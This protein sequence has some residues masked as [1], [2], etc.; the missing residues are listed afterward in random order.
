MAHRV[1][2]KT[3]DRNSGEGRR[4]QL[5]LSDGIRL[6]GLFRRTP[7]IANA[8]ARRRRFCARL[9]KQ[10][11]LAI[12]DG[13]IE[14]DI[15]PLQHACGRKPRIMRDEARNIE[16]RSAASLQHFQRRICASN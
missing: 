11:A 3:Y 10:R 7:E 1:H 5:R 12:E 9:R 15:G 14:Q 8:L 6:E 4:T 13:D 16:T 2:A